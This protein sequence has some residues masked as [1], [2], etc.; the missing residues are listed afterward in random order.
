[1][2]GVLKTQDF[3]GQLNPVGEMTLT[4]RHRKSQVKDLSVAAGGFWPW[5]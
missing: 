5:W 3:T 4:F 2:H 1:M